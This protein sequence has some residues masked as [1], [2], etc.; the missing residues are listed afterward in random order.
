MDQAGEQQNHVA[1]LIHDRAVA[2]AAA[3]L[4]GKL[5]LDALVGR[6]VPLEVVVAVGKVDILL[7]EDGCPLERSG[8][9]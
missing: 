3:D 5:V 9:A 4:A 8:C 6:V 7:V 2:V 1:A